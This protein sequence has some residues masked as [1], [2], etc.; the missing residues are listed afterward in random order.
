[1]LRAV[2]RQHAGSFVVALALVTGL[3][4]VAVPTRAHACSCAPPRPPLES[5]AAASVVFEGRTFGVTREGGQN[6]FTFEV[7]RVLKGEVPS[8][9]HIWSASHSASCGRAFEAGLPY[10]VYAHVLPG[11]QLGDGLCSRTRPVSNAAEDL[12][13]LGAGHPPLSAPGASSPE[14]PPVEP[15][16][17]EPVAQET[18]PAPSKRGCSIEGATSPLVVSLVLLGC[19]RR[20]TRRGTKP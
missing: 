2:T 6:R 15:P 14:A 10:L 16:R 7:L 9:V 1:M 3:A 13:L 11:G 17:I 8:S 20:R 4:A 5:A 12:E 18:A 19:A